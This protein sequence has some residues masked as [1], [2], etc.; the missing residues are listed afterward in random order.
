M[1]FLASVVDC[2]VHARCSCT[3]LALWESARRR[4]VMSAS[5]PVGGG[6]WKGMGVSCGWPFRHA[7]RRVS[8]TSCRKCGIHFPGLLDHSKHCNP[9]WPLVTL[10]CT[11]GA[12]GNRDSI[13][14]QHSAHLGKQQNDRCFVFGRCARKMARWRPV[15]SRMVVGD[16]GPH[17]GVAAAHQRQMSLPSWRT[18]M[19]N[20]VEFARKEEAEEEDER[21][22][23]GG[24]HKTE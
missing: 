4:L 12:M 15:R 16:C 11:L 14:P 10:L 24:R 22:T 6:Q 2:S 20:V 7:P 1:G 3:L 18:A 21:R 17:A 23:T 19:D 13:G 9:R 5:R 8:L